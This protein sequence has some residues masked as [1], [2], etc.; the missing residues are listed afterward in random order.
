[1]KAAVLLYRMA[2]RR[3]FEPVSSSDFFEQSGK[4]PRQLKRSR[5]R[6]GLCPRPARRSCHRSCWYAGKKRLVSAAGKIAFPQTEDGLYCIGGGLG[7]WIGNGREGAACWLLALRGYHQRQQIELSRPKS[8]RLIMY[9]NI[10]PAGQIALPG[11]S[12]E[13]Q[14]VLDDKTAYLQAISWKVGGELCR[15]F[16]QLASW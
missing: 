12:V 10:L 4:W 5:D 6:I 13:A 14:I 15:R 3:Q 7:R 8:A 16:Y 9:V 1:M 2:M 11:A